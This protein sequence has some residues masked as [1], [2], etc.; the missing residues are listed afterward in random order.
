MALSRLHDHEALLAARE[1][2]ERP[3]S[4]EEAAPV[5]RLGL[6]AQ[7]LAKPDP[8]EASVETCQALLASHDPAEQTAGQF[9]RFS[10]TDWEF[11]N[12]LDVDMV[13]H[14]QGELRLPFLGH[15]WLYRWDRHL[16]ALAALLEA[17]SRGAAAVPRP[18]RGGGPAGLMLSSPLL[19]RR[20][21]QAVAG[22]LEYWRWHGRAHLHAA[23]EQALADVLI[24]AVRSPVGDVAA[25]V[26][27][28]W[29]DNAGRLPQGRLLPAL[30]HR[31]IGLMP[32]LSEEMRQRFASWIDVRGLPSFQPTAAERSNPYATISEANLDVLE[33]QTHDEDETI[34][35][36]AARRLLESGDPG[37]RRLALS[38]DRPDVRWPLQLLS[39]LEKCK[40]DEL[41]AALRRS[42]GQLRRRPGGAVSRR[43]DV[44]AAGR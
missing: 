33:A 25:T 23:W 32:G 6:C 7:L 24:E 15:A 18:G 38:L 9:A 22:V 3:V 31:L 14:W 36:A 43:N 21:W 34:A 5:L 16:A 40:H 27:L 17:D 37:Q 28:H 1:E 19:S 4:E 44:V 35:V 12:R 11:V 39:E 26:I 42:G 2:E 8:V 41:Q 10:R 20:T 13:K 29:R 30:R